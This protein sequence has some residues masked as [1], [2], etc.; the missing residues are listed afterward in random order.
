MKFLY[1]F[2][3][4]AHPS[5]SLS[6][7]IPPSPSLSLFLHPSLSPPYLTLAL[8]VPKPE[9]VVSATERELVSGS[10]LYLSCSIQ[11]PSVNTSITIL[12]N[13]TTPGS[14]HD[15]VNAANDTRPELVISSVET[16]DSGD[17][18]CSVRVTDS[19]DSQ[20]VLDSGLITATVTITVSKWK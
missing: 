20:Y 1:V 9:V 3:N 18:T 19:S 15:R 11:P 16:A 6:F 13:W 10:P 12:S 2:R 8:S 14:R 4:Y 5:L 7:Y 17:Y